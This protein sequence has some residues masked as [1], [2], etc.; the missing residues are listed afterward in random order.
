MNHTD[1]EVSGT[2]CLLSSKNSLGNILMAGDR[3]WKLAASEKRRLYAWWFKHC[4]F[5]QHLC[6]Y[7]CHVDWCK[8]MSEY[9]RFWTCKSC[10]F[11]VNGVWLNMGHLK[12]FTLWIMMVVLDVTQRHHVI[13]IHIHVFAYSNSWSTVNLRVNY[14]F[15]GPST[16]QRRHVILT[17]STPN[18]SACWYALHFGSLCPEPL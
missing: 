7:T 5:T 10:R 14:S 3:L 12:R 16:Y 1:G 4:K 18:N 15:W 2:C 9:A 11:G 8:S 6:F 13:F 17:S